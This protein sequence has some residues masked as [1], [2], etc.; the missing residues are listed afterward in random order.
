MPQPEYERRGADLAERAG[1]DGLF[2]ERLRLVL[3]YLQDSPYHRPEFDKALILLRE[4][5]AEKPVLRA[6]DAGLFALL[7]VVARGGGCG[8]KS[9]ALQ[10]QIDFLLS[11]NQRLHQKVQQ[12]EKEAAIAAKKIEALKKIEQIISDRQ[13]KGTSGGQNSGR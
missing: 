4:M 5:S 6:D 3:F 11:E 8:E 1:A 9:A 2:E 12:S 10:H 13:I 7:R